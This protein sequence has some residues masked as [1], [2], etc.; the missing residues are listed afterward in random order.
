MVTLK[1]GLEHYTPGAI[2]RI[3]EMH[4]SYYSRNH[5]FG[6]FFEAMVARELSGLLMGFNPAH[7]GFWTA[8]HGSSVI[9]SVAVDGSRA[10]KE[11]ARLRFLIVASEFQCL[12][13]GKRLVGAAVDFCREKGFNKVF[14]TT[15]EGLHPAR[16]IYEDAGFRLVSEK[17]GAHWGK[18]E[19]EQ[20]FELNLES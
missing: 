6:I 11:G 7:D 20:V 9:G 19:L 10:E 12:G 15:F 18:P 14:L 16:R 4:A 17:K 3:T 1:S 8:E 5:G 13:I 2:G